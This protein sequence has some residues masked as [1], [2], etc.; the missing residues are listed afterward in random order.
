MRDRGRN[1]A[2]SAEC[3]KSFLGILEEVSREGAKEAKGRRVERE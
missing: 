2:A 1:K 3:R